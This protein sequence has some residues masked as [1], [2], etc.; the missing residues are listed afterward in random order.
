MEQQASYFIWGIDNSPYGPVELPMLLDWIN[1]GRVA[2]R[3]VGLRKECRQL[4][5]GVAVSRTEQPIC[6][7]PFKFGECHPD[8][9]PFASHQNSRPFK[10]CPTRALADF[11]EPQDTRNI[12]WYSNRATWVTRIYLVLAGNYA[13]ADDGRRKGNDLDHVRRG[14]FFGDMAFSITARVRQTS[15]RTW[16]AIF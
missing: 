1:E 12:R 3:Y 13:G 15:W 11:M 7:R 5:K 8:T 4:G 9:R 2:G 14:D 6:A 16:T 10:S